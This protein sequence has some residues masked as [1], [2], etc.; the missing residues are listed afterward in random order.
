V[1]LASLIR[2]WVLIWRWWLG[3]SSRKSIPSK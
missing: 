1:T 3:E 2:E